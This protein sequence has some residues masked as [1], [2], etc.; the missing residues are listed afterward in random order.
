MK[1]LGIDIGIS[2]LGICKVENGRIKHQVYFS[3]NK[4]LKG[5]EKYKEF[6]KSHFCHPAIPNLIANAD[7]IIIEKPFNIR[8]YGAILYEL[9]GIIRYFLILYN[10][11]FIEIPQTTLKK[12][13]TGK[14][15][16]P[17]SDM[18]KHAIK[19]YGFEAESE[20]EVDAFWCAM[21]GL[22]VRGDRDIDK[23]SF[24]KARKDSLKKLVT[25]N[26]IRL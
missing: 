10:K 16:A 3:G 5:F 21:A 2:K 24:S 13:A 12:F 18:V 6:I 1:I 11:S 23:K 8:G 9:F 25:Q 22:C 20:D 4:K 19:E 15:N 14:G 17:K 7:L 26:S